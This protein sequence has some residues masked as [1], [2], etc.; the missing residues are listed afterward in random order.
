MASTIHR[1]QPGVFWQDT[2][3]LDWQAAGKPGIALKPVRSDPAG[4]FLGLVGFEP[5]TRS[6]LH[7]HQATATSFFIDGSLTDY[8]GSAGLHQAGI[9]LKGATH[10]AMAYQRTVLV[11]RLEGPVTYPPEAGPLHGLHAGASHQEVVN[12]APEVAPEINVSVDALA[13]APTGLPT[14]TRKL[15]F[16]YR[17]TGHARRMVQL[18]LLPGS[19]WPRFRTTATVDVWVRGGEI[20]LDN[21]RLHAN[22]F[23][24]IDPDREVT[25]HSPYGALLI[26]WAEGPLHWDCSTSADPFGFQS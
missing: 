9:N 22:C 17:G 16:D 5:M 14:T 7:Q 4:L 6:G 11:S 26:A 15:I 19:R 20:H 25:L 10:D 1:I 21:A 2:A 13:A 23:A 8:H 18:H 3:E 12:A 24:V